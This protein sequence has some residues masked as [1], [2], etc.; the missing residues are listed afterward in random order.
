MIHATKNAQMAVWN[1]LIH[2]RGEN[3]EDARRI[4]VG[5]KGLE[6]ND[7][8]AESWPEKSRALEPCGSAPSFNCAAKFLRLP[9]S[10]W[11][12]DKT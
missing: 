9:G 7:V 1:S 11:G 5:Y 2:Q 4:P 3:C 6:T 8:I 10:I 12:E